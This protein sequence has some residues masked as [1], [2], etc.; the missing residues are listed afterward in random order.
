VFPVN[1]PCPPPGVPL[2]AG[3]KISCGSSPG[4]IEEHDKVIQ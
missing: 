4:S 1:G 2:G 3:V